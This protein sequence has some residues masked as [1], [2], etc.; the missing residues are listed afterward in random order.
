MDIYLSLANLFAVVT[1]VLLF[2][3]YELAIT[4]HEYLNGAIVLAVITF[5]T[6]VVLLFNI[7]W[8]VLS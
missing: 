6:T 8:G 5:T 3:I 2:V 7:S 1:L 4:D